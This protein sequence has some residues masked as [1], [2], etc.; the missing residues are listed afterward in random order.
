MAVT[1]LEPPLPMSV[2]DKGDGHAI[3]VNSFTRAFG[4]LSVTPFGAGEYRV[5]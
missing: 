4:L 2:I 1:Q 5:R 3:A